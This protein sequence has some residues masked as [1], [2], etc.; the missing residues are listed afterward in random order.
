MIVSEPV[1]FVLEIVSAVVVG[2]MLV[3]MRQAWH[4]VRALPRNRH[5]EHGLVVSSGLAV[6]ALAN[7]LTGVGFV[8][9]DEDL[10]GTGAVMVRGAMAVVAVY[11]VSRRPQVRK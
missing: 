2:M 11:L 4:D 6:I 3:V 8:Q 5:A 7:V 9:G 1:A 10:I